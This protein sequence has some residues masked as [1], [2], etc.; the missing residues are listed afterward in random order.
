M[1]V[2]MRTPRDQTREEPVEY[3]DE[4]TSRDEHE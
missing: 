3:R 2:L 4:P 1:R